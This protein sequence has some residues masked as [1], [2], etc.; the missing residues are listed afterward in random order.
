MTIAYKQ[1]LII[2]VGLIGG[3]IA[4]AAKSLD[5]PPI[6]Y[7][8][9]TDA[10]TVHEALEKGFADHAALDS[11]EKAKKWLSGN[12][13]TFAIDLIVLA[14]PA[15]AAI[16]WLKRIQEAGFKGTITDV[17]STKGALCRAA[18][19][20][21][22]EPDCFIPGHPM[23]GSEVN[24]IEGARATLFKGAHWILC[25]DGSDSSA[26]V[27]AANS[28]L[29][30]ATDLKESV[31]AKTSSDTTTD[32]KSKTSKDIAT[33]K[34]TKTS[35]DT[36]INKDTQAAERF[37]DLHEFVLALGARPI[38]VDR[39]AHDDVIAIVSHVPHMLA[40]ALVQLAGEHASKSEELFRLA[41][42]GFKDTTRIAAG[43]AEL[44]SGIAID[45][46]E[47]LAAGLGELKQ[48]VATFE[49]A[50]RQCDT[51]RVKA[52][53]QSAAD[54]RQAIPAQWLP[55]TERLVEFRV[56]MAN[57][58]GVVAEVTGLAAKAGCN[59]VSIDIDH[60]TA[61]TAMLELV[62]TD[63]GDI[64]RFSGALWDAGFDV[65]MHPLTN[66]G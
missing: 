18:A 41:A 59:I 36:K 15:S 61:D 48:I 40:A 11:C 4:A 54:L 6:V 56:A 57:R 23:A 50:V 47:A 34:D 1:I 8:I 55:K 16:E 5:E 17:A 3:S 14:T 65:F 12:G 20:I 19:D 63:E 43:S 29:T 46:H 13:E 58:S 30:A 45:N 38:T 25:P 60:M 44:W 53:L 24:G 9:D 52:L 66:A 49:D 10:A 22:V 35:N 64:G 31:D 33:D 51:S 27:M 39:Y 7:A 28:A 32:E 26:N 42:G 37:I 62:L 21:L 2:G